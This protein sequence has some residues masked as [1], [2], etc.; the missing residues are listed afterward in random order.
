MNY[1]VLNWCKTNIMMRQIS[2]FPLSGNFL[3]SYH[4]E[5][6]AVIQM[7]SVK[8]VLLEISQNPQENTCVRV[9]FLKKLQAFFIKHLW[10]LF[11]IRHF[12]AITRSSSQLVNRSSH[13][14]C[15][16]SIRK[17][18]LKISQNSQ[19]NTCGRVSFL[20]KLQA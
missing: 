2:I 14:S 19:E 7:C 17:M 13:Q 4:H 1:L 16:C 8:K 5:R 9:S 11:L 15:R 20:I 3:G 12:Q 18:S 10:W 6:E